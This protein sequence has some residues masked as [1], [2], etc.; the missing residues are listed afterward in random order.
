MYGVEGKWA[1]VARAVFSGSFWR[2]G[3][4][5]GTSDVMIRCGFC[6]VPWE[7]CGLE[8]SCV[9]IWARLPLQQNGCTW[10]EDP[11]AVS[12]ELCTGPS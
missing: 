1:G 4:Q 9:P 2:Q 8:P 10:C 5:G 11:Q 3:V 6:F 12:R 7:L